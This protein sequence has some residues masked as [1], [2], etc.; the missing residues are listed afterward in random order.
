[1][2]A[3]VDQDGIAFGDG[4]MFGKDL[5]RKTAKVSA[6]TERLD[7]DPSWTRVAVV[8]RANRQSL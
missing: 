5:G 3:I 4:I 1:M 8:R 7:P 2:N 6:A